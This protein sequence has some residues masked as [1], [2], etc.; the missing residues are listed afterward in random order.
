MKAYT[1]ERVNR[2]RPPLPTE[3]RA[4]SFDLDDT[5]WPVDDVIQRAEAHL[6][7]VMQDEFPRIF[8]HHDESSLREHRMAVYRQYPEF[9]H[10]VTQ[11]RLRALEHILS[12]HDYALT[13]VPML[14]QAFLSKRNDVRLFEDVLHCLGELSAK[15]PLIALS[16]GNSCVQEAGLGEYFNRHITAIEV[17]HKKP[18]QK[19][20]D[21]LLDAAGVPAETILHVGDHPRDDVLGALNAGMQSAWITRFGQNWPDE[22]AHRPDHH[23]HD[24]HPLLALI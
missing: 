16:N 19:M 13:H 14:M 15:V 18:S 23:I 24:L 22:H 9:S 5:L 3:I 4:I 2:R 11:L 20:F 8:E 6:L 7:R 1:R 12:E 21:A 10:D 17:G